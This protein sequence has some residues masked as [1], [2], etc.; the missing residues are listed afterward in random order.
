MPT[1]DTSDAGIAKY[2]KLLAEVRAETPDA[3]HVIDLIRDA[4]TLLTR[5][6]KGQEM[7]RKWLH[8]KMNNVVQNMILGNNILV[9][10]QPLCP[11][12]M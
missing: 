1:G 11:K 9:F 7:S 12:S 5:M 6:H 3:T 8:H 4:I 2:E 10:T